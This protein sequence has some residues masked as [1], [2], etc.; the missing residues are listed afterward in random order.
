MEEAERRAEELEVGK[1]ELLEEFDMDGDG[2]FDYK[3]AK[4]AVESA[5]LQISCKF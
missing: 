3:D 5:G 4:V 2:D 1:D